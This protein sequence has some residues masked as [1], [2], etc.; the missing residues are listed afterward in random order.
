[1]KDVKEITK[2]LEEGLKKVFES[3][4]YLAYLN[5]MSKFHNYSYSNCMLILQQYPTAS[6]VA[7]YKAWQTKF[8]R[9]VKKG[10]KGIYILAPMPRTIK[11]VNEETGEEEEYKYNSYRPVAV[12]DISQT[13]GEALPAAPKAKPLKGKVKGFSKIM[14]T[15]KGMASVP[16]RM[17]DDCDGANGYCSPTEIVLLKGMSEAQ[18]I[19]TMTHELAHHLLGHSD[20]SKE[21]RT[22]KEVQAESVAYIVAQYIGLDTEEYSFPYITGWASERDAK[23]LG[24]ILGRV[25]KTADKIIKEC[26]KSMSVA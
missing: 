21:D 20:G 16:V 14:R 25:Q 13:D 24:S 10:E 5:V 1:M 11:K 3:S 19:K 23:S 9:H 4:E 15:L 18:T 6:R 12:F 22:T 8:K 26:E 7:G 17:A 2:K